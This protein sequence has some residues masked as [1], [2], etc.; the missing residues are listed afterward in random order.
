MRYR[1]IAYCDAPGCRC[2]DRSGLVLYDGADRDAALDRQEAAPRGYRVE[3][4]TTDQLLR[5]HT[6]VLQYA[7][8]STQNR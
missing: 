3:L 4:E 5:S 2:L 6:S 1:T 8:E 7:G